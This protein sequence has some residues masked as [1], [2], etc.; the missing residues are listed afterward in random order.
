MS[1]STP[2]HEDPE[3]LKE[4]KNRISAMT[5][6]EEVCYDSGHADGFKLGKEAAEVCG[7][8]LFEAARA[9]FCHMHWDNMPD[10]VVIEFK[11]AIANAEARKHAKNQPST[12]Y[13]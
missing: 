10:E 5:K 1:D 6:D 7:A 12:Q 8:E 13:L 9:F 2:Y 4:W 11:A 3:R